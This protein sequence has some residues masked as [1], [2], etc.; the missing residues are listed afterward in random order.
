MRYIF[1]TILLILTIA[2]WEY[3]KSTTSTIDSDENAPIFTDQNGNPLLGHS[4]Q[5]LDVQAHGFILLAKD[6]L[7]PNDSRK[8]VATFLNPGV[9]LMANELLTGALKDIPVPELKN[10][11][12]L[13][14]DHQ[15]DQVLAYATTNQANF[16]KARFKLDRVLDPFLYAIAIERGYTAASLLQENASSWVTLRE[17]LNRGLNAPVQQV[18]SS[19][20]TRY[21]NWRMQDMGLK[22]SNY[23]NLY[24]IV[25]LYSI[26]ARGGR[27][28][29]LNLIKE[30]RAFLETQ[31]LSEESTTIIS[32][33]LGRTE[34][35]NVIMPENTALYSIHSASMGLAFVYN[36]KYI[37][38]VW[39]EDLQSVPSMNA[40]KTPALIARS[41][42][43]HLIPAERVQPLPLRGQLQPRSLCRN[44]LRIYPADGLCLAWTEL[45]PTST[46]SFKLKR[47][48][49]QR[50]MN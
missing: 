28:R 27:Y 4:P 36:F 43:N 15:S 34:N 40:S 18:L 46:D 9:Q 11:A 30:E 50:Q 8:T 45:M 13:V 31:M 42:M 21:F 16:E 7:A 37:V 29:K 35:K 2:S 48:P 33:I 6:Q 24:D 3:Y 22:N 5:R 1:S 47:V 23:S 10:G 32:S 17:A 14:A 39:L 49:A 26:I 25:S 19:I 38:G 41:L 44:G 12:I 20:G